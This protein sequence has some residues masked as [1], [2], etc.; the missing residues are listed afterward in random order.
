[1]TKEKFILEKKYEEGEGLPNMHDD[2]GEDRI[3]KGPHDE[4]VQKGIVAGQRDIRGK[5]KKGID[6]GE[7]DKADI[8]NIPNLD[9]SHFG[10]EVDE[11]E[12][13]H[14]A[15]DRQLWKNRQKLGILP[16]KEDV[17]L[18]GSQSPRQF[19][20]VAEQMAYLEKRNIAK[21]KAR[22]RYVKEKG[23]IEENDGEKIEKKK[24]A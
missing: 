9:D 8:E 17:V 15:L 2:R 11:E 21:E 10:E 3:S 12:R 19:Q 4:R 5:L 13:I 1:M 22:K 6:Y 23:E 24:A 14:S 18:E 20:S 16:E 7:K